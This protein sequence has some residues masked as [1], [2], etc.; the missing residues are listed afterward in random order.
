MSTYIHPTA[1]VSDKAVL[2][3]GVRIGPFCVVDEDVVLGAGTELIALAHVCRYTKVG[4]NCTIHEN[5]VVGG[6]PQDLSFGGEKSW[7]VIGNNVTIR[8]SVTVNRSCG[9]GSVTSVGDSCMIMEGVHLAHN[10]TV[11]NGCVIANK[12]GLSGYVEIGDYAVIGGMAGFHQFVRVGRYCMVGGMCRVTQDVPP[13]C[14]AAGEP[15]RIFDINKIGLQRR[16]FEPS[17]RQLIRRI[18][19]AI[20]NP[21]LPRKEGLAEAEELYGN[22]DTA[23]IILDFYRTSERGVAPGFSGRKRSGDAN[24][25]N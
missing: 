9:E 21:N 13:Y 19:K 23:K 2:G 1:I 5:A 10:V 15:L 17:E 8:E 12:A 6:I 25:K 14:L 16:G 20:N 11:G 7:V 3:D 18:Y 24:G 4:E 22:E